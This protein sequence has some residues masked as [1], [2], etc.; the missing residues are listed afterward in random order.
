VYHTECYYDQDGDL[1]RRDALKRHAQ[2]LEQ[3]NDSLESIVGSLC[4]LP[5]PEAIA[6]LLEIR[7]GDKTKGLHPPSPISICLPAT[8][9]PLT[10]EYAFLRHMNFWNSGQEQLGLPKDNSA[11]SVQ[12][13]GKDNLSNPYGNPADQ[14]VGFWFRTLQ[15]PEFIDHLLDLYFTWVHPFHQIFSKDRFLTDFRCMATNYCSALL[16]NAIAAFA[17]HYTDAPST[18]AQLRVHTTAG[19]H[20]FAEAKWL[21]T[22]DEEPSLT[23][24]QALGIMGLRETSHGR[25][26]SGYQYMGRCL[27]TALEMGLNLS[28]TSDRLPPAVVEER[29]ITFWGVFNFEAYVAHHTVDGHC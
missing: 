3:K 21:L 25:V 23:T 12:D 17:C 2:S 6:M 11:S 18:V 14:D 28:A 5:E 22:V 15:D 26:G 24:V 1:R 27:R 20:F 7:K 9:G 29:N 4:D 13:L 10:L 19:D 8:L 16:V